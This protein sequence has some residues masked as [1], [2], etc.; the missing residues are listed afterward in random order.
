MDKVLRYSMKDLESIAGLKTSLFPAELTHVKDYMKSRR[1][2][3]E[4]DL[5]TEWALILNGQGREQKQ[6]LWARL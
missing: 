2:F 6:D 5:G 4:L 1:N 3:I